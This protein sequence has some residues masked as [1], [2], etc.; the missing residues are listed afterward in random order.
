MSK[1]R[2]IMKA[3]LCGILVPLFAMA[4][5][6]PAHAWTWN[7]WVTVYN[8]VEFVFK[9]MRE[10]TTS[11]QAFFGQPR[12]PSP[13]GRRCI[14]LCCSLAAR[15][16]PCPT[17]LSSWIT[18]LVYASRGSCCCGSTSTPQSHAGRVRPFKICQMP[19]TACRV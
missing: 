5:A 11:V 4:I 18:R 10:L 17:T 13:S 19:S 2:L 1:F 3:I 16:T 9:V 12:S 7:Q 8:G 14:R 6:S 15:P